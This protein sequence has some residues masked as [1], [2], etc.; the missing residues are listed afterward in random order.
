MVNILIKKSTVKGKKYDAFLNDKKISFGADGYEDYTMHNNEDR[1]K[2]YIARHKK[3]DWTTKNMESP[4]WWSRWLL[5]EKPSIR[6]AI[7]EIERKHPH[8]RITF[9]RK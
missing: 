4:A 6:E 5:W 8:L 2:R 1:K 3:E 7:N 9:M